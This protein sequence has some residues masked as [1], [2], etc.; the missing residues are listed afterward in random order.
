MSSP[1]PAA[2]LSALV[3]ARLLDAPLAGLAWLLLERGVPVIVAGREPAVVDGLLD[4]LVA[5]LPSD[6]RPGPAVGLAGNQLVRVAGCLEIDTPPGILRAALAATTGRSGLALAITADDLGGVLSVL[7]SQG[8]VDDEIS[9]MGVVLVLGGRDAGPAGGRRPDD[10]A[11][12]GG[13]TA[14]LVA[15]DGGDAAR[16]VA[17][18]YLRPVVLDAGGHPRRLAPAILA[19]WD[20]AAAA[21][22]HF[23]W[24]ITPDLAERTRM[25]AGDLER[26]RERRAAMLAGHAHDRPVG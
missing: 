25:R 1:A 11:P 5:A 26:E 2:T 9:F 22:D 21:W 23:S 10:G 16:L 18:H 13:D 7:R 12:D 19:T 4:A 17:A 3:A 6:R 20:P 15:P 24:G 14:R 8:M